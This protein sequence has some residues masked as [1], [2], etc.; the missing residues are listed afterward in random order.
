MSRAMK[1]KDEALVPAADIKLYIDLYDPR[2]LFAMDEARGI[3]I[4]NR[5][6]R[7]V[8]KPGDTFLDIGANHGTY[9][10]NAATAVGASGKVIAFEPQPKLARLIRKSF[11]ANALSQA[12]VLEIACSDT[13]GES[14]FFVPCNWSGEASLFQSDQ[15]GEVQRNR[16][17]LAPLDDLIAD[18]RLPG[19]VVLKI[20]VEGNEAAVLRGAQKTIA[21]YRPYVHL[22]IGALSQSDTA[23]ATEEPLR[24]LVGMG[25]QRFSEIDTFPEWVPLEQ[26]SRTNQRNV[27]AASSLPR[28]D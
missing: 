2:I 10:L 13:V 17:R 23:P 14:D 7:T 26:L 5:F 21:R 3:G 9:S 1:L 15:E 24:I 18:R 27:I 28:K 4:D 20:D 6:L 12:E 11:E 19:N 22:E 8:L 16:V 25:Y